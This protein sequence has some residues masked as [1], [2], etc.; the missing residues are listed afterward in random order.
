[1]RDVEF[2]WISGSRLIVNRGM[3]GATGNIYCGLHEFCDMEFLLHLLRPG[4]LFLDVGSNI[5]S[6]A[7][8]A[9]K[10]CGATS[11]A[12]EPDPDTS[13]LL[14]R[15]IAANDLEELVT[16]YE[17]ALNSEDGYVQFTVGNDTTN[18]IASNLDKNVRNV[19]SARLDGVL[20]VTNAIFMK[21][22]VEGG[23]ERVL[24]GAPAVLASPSLIAIESEAQDQAVVD[25]LA[26]HGF[27]RMYYDPV[28]RSLTIE[29][30]QYQSS[31]GL[32]I[33]DVVAVRSRIATSAVRNFMGFAF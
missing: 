29:P 4:D 17:L 11:I 14:R 7:V 28:A 20:Q 21:L 1:M 5:G 33:R 27:E 24:A 32:F 12:F 8:L 10:V 9:S 31:N 18:R 16:V 30:N 6:Y 13:T 3:T 23:E 26:A 19:S 25:I 15:N 22:D 2:E